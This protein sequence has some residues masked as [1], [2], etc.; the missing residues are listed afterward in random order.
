MSNICYGAYVLVDSSLQNRY[1]KFWDFIKRT[2]TKLMKVLVSI[3]GRHPY[4][5]G[6]SSVLQPVMGFCLNNICNSD[7]ATFEPFL[8]Q[9]MIMVKSV[10]ECKEY[11]PI[12]TGRVMD[13]SGVSVEQ[14]KKNMSNAVGHLLSSL[15]PNDQ[16]VLLCDVLI[17]RYH[18]SF[19]LLMCVTLK[20]L[21]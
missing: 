16:I 2:C 17:R 9:C 15:M 10:I 1:P 5:F 3:Q 19:R 8:I 11:K 21:C 12:L 4:S 13:E 6:D 7:P 14:M 18:Y 20:N